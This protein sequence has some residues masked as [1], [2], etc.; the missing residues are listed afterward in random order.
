M[1]KS[2]EGSTLVEVL[3][4]FVILAGAMILSLR[5][6]ADGLRGLEKA[7]ERSAMAAVA[8]RELARLELS[9]ALEAGAFAGND[10]QGFAW[11]IE[12]RSQEN[13]KP[14][15]DAV[16]PF[17]VRLMVGRESAPGMYPVS[18]DTILLAAPQR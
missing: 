5:I 3:V 11:S 8:R 14:K 2:E 17:R 15:S 18:A 13:T 10:E 12:I 16:V 6:F 1:R 7:E 4:A 9:P